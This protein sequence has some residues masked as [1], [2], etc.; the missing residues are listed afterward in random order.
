MT[1]WKTPD[2]AERTTS[3]TAEIG[4]T[5]CIITSLIGEPE[6]R[7]CVYAPCASVAMPNLPTLAAAQQWCER[8]A[9][10]L[11]G[12]TGEKV[13]ALLEKAA[14]AREGLYCEHCPTDGSRCAVCHA[15]ECPACAGDGDGPANEPCATCHG[16]GRVRDVEA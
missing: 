12:V 11:C 9:A 6:C 13:L 15:H 3:L 7:A 2:R 10:L 1:T 16:E 4:D 14:P 5:I 8:A